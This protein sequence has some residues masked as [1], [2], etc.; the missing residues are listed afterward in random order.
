[1]RAGG[2]ASWQPPCAR[3]HLSACGLRAGP[4]RLL[5]DP[6]S[7]GYLQ[8]PISVYYCY[9]TDRK[10]QRC[11][12]EVCG[13]LLGV[14]QSAWQRSRQPAVSHSSFLQIYRL[15]L[16]PYIRCA[17]LSRIRRTRAPDVMRHHGMHAHNTRP[18]A[19]CPSRAWHRL[20]GWLRSRAGDEHTLGRACEICVPPRR[21]GGAK[22]AARVALH[23]HAQHMVRARPAVTHPRATDMAVL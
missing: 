20:F 1:M 6:I 4:V 14:C 15:A 10:L 2:H 17:G 22:S 21:R 8:N 9:T 18:Q 23:G 7:A 11:I 3:A 16:Q 13:E 12:A 19:C 5:T